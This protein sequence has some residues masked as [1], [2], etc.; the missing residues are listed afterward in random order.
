MRALSYRYRFECEKINKE[1]GTMEHYFASIIMSLKQI[2]EHTFGKTYETKEG[3]LNILGI[4]ARDQFAEYIDIDCI[5]LFEH[6]KVMDD[7]ERMGYIMFRNGQWIFEVE[8]TLEVVPLEK[9]YWYIRKIGTRWGDN[10]NGE[11]R[12]YDFKG[13]EEII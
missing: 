3:T 4:V 13:F 2:E 7:K 9:C 12:R 10:E 8:D 5:E 1:K 6:D 11:V